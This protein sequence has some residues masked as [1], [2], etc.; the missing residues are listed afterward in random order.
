MISSPFILNS[1]FTYL[2]MV[3][4]SQSLLKPIYLFKLCHSLCQFTRANRFNLFQPQPCC[5]KILIL[6][7]VINSVI[8]NSLIVTLFRFKSYLSSRFSVVRN[9]ELLL[10]SFH[11]VRSVI[12]LHFGTSVVQCRY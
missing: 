8:L 5:S 12:S 11:A 2:S 10:K 1:N 4:L 3:L 7:C 9:R 6:L